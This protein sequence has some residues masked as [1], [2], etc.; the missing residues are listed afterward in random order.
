MIIPMKPGN[1]SIYNAIHRKRPCRAFPDCQD[2]PSGLF[3]KIRLHRIPLT[4]AIQFRGPEFGSCFWQ[5]E[6]P[7]PF[8]SMP[9]TTVDENDCPEPGQNDVRPPRHARHMEPIT[10]APSMQ[11]SSD[12][13]FR[14]RVFAPDP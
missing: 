5:A 11:A 2:T 4:V 9:E 14:P 8:M 12:Q 7:A 13:H 10:K 3:Q 1:N 6:I